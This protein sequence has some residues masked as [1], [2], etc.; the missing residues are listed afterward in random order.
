LTDDKINRNLLVWLKSWDPIVF[1]K[2]GPAQTKKIVTPSMFNR[3]LNSTNK[4]NQ[5]ESKDSYL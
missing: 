1:N 3:A 4:Y 5:G 2:H